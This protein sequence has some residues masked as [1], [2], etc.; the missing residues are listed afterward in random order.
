MFKPLSVNPIKWS[1]TLKQF[2]GKLPENC[3]SVLT[4]LWGWLLKGQNINKKNGNLREYTIN[5]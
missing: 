4:I 3:L 5:H 2:D 1:N